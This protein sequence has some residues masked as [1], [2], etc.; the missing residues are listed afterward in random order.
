M[1]G[2]DVA[3]MVLRDW[4]CGMSRGGGNGVVS[5]EDGGIGSDGY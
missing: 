2:E 4:G 3:V 1:R 5:F